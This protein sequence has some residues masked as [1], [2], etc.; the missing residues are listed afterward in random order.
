LFS[1]RTFTAYAAAIVVAAA[2]TVSSSARSTHSLSAKITTRVESPHQQL[3]TGKMQITKAVQV[4]RFLKHHPRAGTYQSHQRVRRNHLWLLRQGHVNITLAQKRLAAIEAAKRAEA[5]AALRQQMGDGAEFACI[6]RYEGAWNSN[7]GNG[8]YGG[9]QMDLGFQRT[10]GPEFISRW[11]TADNWP[12][13]AQVTA[14]RRAR[15][16]YA[17]YGAR[18]YGPWPNTARSCGLL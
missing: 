4:L 3:H 14:A 17:G 8:Y 13:W 9:L 12:V 1:L 2:F 7:T 5:E 6:H 11:G 15:D 10:Y 18:G 16:G